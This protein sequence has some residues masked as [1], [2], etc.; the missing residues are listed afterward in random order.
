[1]MSE[2]HGIKGGTTDETFQEQLFWWE[3][4]APVSTDF[5][6]FNFKDLLNEQEA[7]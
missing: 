5:E 4:G 6:L 1:M 3:R 7:I 2:S